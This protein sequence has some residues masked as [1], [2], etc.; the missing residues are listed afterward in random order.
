MDVVGRDGLQDL[1]RYKC[2]QIWPLACDHV[3]QYTAGHIPQAQNH[4]DVTEQ[5]HPQDDRHG[6]YTIQARKCLLCIQLLFLDSRLAE[7]MHV[8][9]GI[10]RTN[11]HSLSARPHSCKFFCFGCALRFSL[12]DQFQITKDNSQS[13]ATII[14]QA[15][16][17]WCNMTT[18][19][20]SSILNALIGKVRHRKLHRLSAATLGVSCRNDT[21]VRKS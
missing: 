6:C 19:G 16:L 18:P 15:V 12:P 5:I 17:S 2:L 13:P 1:R 14:C 3:V 4:L 7:C 21:Q 20:K 9:H 10:Q 11:C 8:E